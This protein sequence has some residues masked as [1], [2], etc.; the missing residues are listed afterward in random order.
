M[1]RSIVT[2]VL[3]YKFA[4]VT[5]YL[6][7]ALIVTIFDIFKLI[8]DYKVDHCRP[9]RAALNAVGHWRPAAILNFYNVELVKN[10]KEP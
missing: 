9:I 6:E 3:M 7:F 8:I 4:K 1:H 2:D 10:D 5:I